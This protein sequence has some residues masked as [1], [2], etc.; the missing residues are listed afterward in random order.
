MH[1]HMASYMKMWIKCKWIDF[2]VQAYIYFLRRIHNMTL[3]N[4][5]QRLSFR[6]SQASKHIQAY[7]NTDAM[8]RVAFILLRC[9][10]I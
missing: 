3:A 4:A 8:D 9:E 6:G 2:Q 5:Y 10:E 7:A 1:T